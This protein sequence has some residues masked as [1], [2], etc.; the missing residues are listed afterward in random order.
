M[1]SSQIGFKIISHLSEQLKFTF[2]TSEEDEKFT[3]SLIFTE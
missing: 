2:E 1:F 3:T